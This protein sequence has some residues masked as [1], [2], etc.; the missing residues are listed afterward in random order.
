MSKT[1]EE[2]LNAVAQRMAPWFAEVGLKLPRVRMSIGFPS[3]GSRGK[4]IGE[5]WSF[6]ASA[7]ATHEIFIRPDRHDTVEV[8]AIQLHE[9]IHAAVGIDKGH[10]PEFRRVAV[11]LGLEGKMTATVA[12]ELFRDRFAPIHRELGDIPHAELRLGRSSGPKKQSTRMVKCECPECG[13]TIRTTRKW[14]DQLGAPICPAPDHGQ[15]VA[16]LPPDDGEDGDDAG[17]E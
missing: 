5:C 13:Y 16:E 4:A 12:G 14:I 10:G 2:W 6:E 15:M 7:D 17:D 11:A 1:R 9:L 3:K 8:A